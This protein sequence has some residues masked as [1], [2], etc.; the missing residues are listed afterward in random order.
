MFG[1]LGRSNMPG[2]WQ[3]QHCNSTTDFFAATST[4]SLPAFLRDRMVPS[5][6]DQTLLAQPCKCG[7]EM[8]ITY[9]FPRREKEVLQVIRMVGIEWSPEYLMMMWES[10]PASD[11]NE[12][13]FDF[14]YLRGRN[15]WGLN[16][17]L[18]PQ[19]SLKQIFALFRHKAGVLDFP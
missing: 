17:A 18:F 5:G 19:A 6:W 8:R 14:K 7:A 15:P 2:W 1:E 16:K 10:A 3:C 13:W 11:P 4:Q 9:H 12:R